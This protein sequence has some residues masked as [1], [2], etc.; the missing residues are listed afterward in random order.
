MPSKSYREF[1][2][3]HRV[4]PGPACKL[5][6]E[7]PGEERVEISIYL[8]PRNGEPAAPAKGSDRRA[9]MRA[10]RAAQ[11]ASDIE[12][13]RRFAREHGLTVSAVEPGRRLVRLSGTA[14]QAQAAFQTKL[15]HYSDGKRT[16]RARTGALS[17]PAELLPVVESV[18]GLDTR[19]AAQPRLVSRPAAAAAA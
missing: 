18:L 17:L 16:F 13:I 14:A 10:H 15:S 19:P 12:L 5:I 9:A 11:H 1:S 7:V 8:K 6:G 4:A 3:S 2:A